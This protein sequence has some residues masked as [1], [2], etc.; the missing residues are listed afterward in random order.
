MGLR[1][2]IETIC[3]ALAIRDLAAHDMDTDAEIVNSC[4]MGWEG[5]TIKVVNGLDQAV[6]VT[7]YGNDAD[8]TTNADAFA[9]TLNVPAGGVGSLLLYAHVDGWFPYVYPSI[10]VPGGVAPTTGTISI[11]IV[12]IHREREG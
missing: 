1:D 12:K 10:I 7:M 3:G 5:F 2:Q 8:N 11:T 4:V 6:V 9:T